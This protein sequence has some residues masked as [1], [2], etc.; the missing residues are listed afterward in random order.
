MYCGDAGHAFAGRRIELDAVEPV[1][2]G[3]ELSGQRPVGADRQPGRLLLVDRNLPALGRHRRDDLHAHLGA[4]KNRDVAA[5]FNLPGLQAGV[6]GEVVLELQLLHVRHVHDVEPE[7][8]RAHA[9][10]FHEV[11]ERSGEVEQHA[12]EFRVFPNQRHTLERP[13]GSL[14]HHQHRLLGGEAVQLRRDR[15]IRALWHADVARL[16]LDL[17][18]HGRFDAARHQHER[19][20]RVPQIGRPEPEQRQ[21]GEH[22]QAHRSGVGV[23]AA[24]ARHGVPL[25]ARG[26]SLSRSRPAA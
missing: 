15:L 22:D 24:C 13:V 16:H 1:L 23:Q 4:A 11:V 14:A 12:L 20:E 17:V 6:R 10:R 5:V 19:G 21:R 3:D 7:G 2:V 9:A 8:R 18:G 25:R 26:P